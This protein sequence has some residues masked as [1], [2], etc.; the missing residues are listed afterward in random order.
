[1]FQRL[2]PPIIVII[3]FF[4]TLFIYTKSAGPL[5]F[6]VNSVSTTKS[7][8][9][10]V[11]GEG[12]V[13]V[14]PDIVVVNLGVSANG[15]TVKQ[16]QDQINT[17]INKVT[18]GVKKLGVDSKDIQTSNYNINPNIDYTAG[19]KINGYT[20]NTNLT[21]K[22][23]DLNKVNEV[24][25]SATQNG[26]NQV[27]GITFDASDKTKAENEAR[28]KAIQDAKSKAEQAAK[29]AGFSLGRLINY[30]EGFNNPPRPYLTAPSAVGTLEKAD[31]SIEP[32]SS[33]IT[34]SVTLSYEIR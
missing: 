26:A 12:K 4:L 13:N 21:I 23:R 9:F 15:A 2:L 11:S 7:D 8:T 1:M 5:P 30:Q 22:V 34:I 32:G 33:E 31:T 18:E 28:Q 6:S 20:A 17:N 14:I 29:I 3:F 24:I 10:N 16:V 25:D 19:Q 27:G